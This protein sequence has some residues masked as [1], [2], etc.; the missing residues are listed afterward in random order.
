MRGL[1]PEEFKNLLLSVGSHRDRR[2]YTPLEVARCFR[3]AIEAGAS[4]KN[5]AQ[6]VHFDGTSMVSRFLRLLELDSKIQYYVD[7]GRTGTTIAFTAASELVRLK[8]EDQGVACIEA[9]KN[10]LS[11]SEVKQL[12]QLRLRSK[13]PIAVCISEVLAL[14]PQVARPHL[15]IGAIKSN[16]VRAHLAALPQSKR[17]EILST[18]LKDLFPDLLTHSSRLG[19]DSFTISGSDSVAAAL[20]AKGIDFEEL[21]NDLLKTRIA[22]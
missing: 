3:K 21:I 9:L 15:L 22:E 6:A 4:L 7:W 18:I 10:I 19:S 16:D 5:C 8:V 20:T 12:V 14:R 13:K 17:D 11:T 1:Q 2:A